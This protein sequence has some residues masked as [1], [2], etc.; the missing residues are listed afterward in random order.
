M[1]YVNALA[2]FSVLSN[3]I[4]RKASQGAFKLVCV[5]ILHSKAPSRSFKVKQ[6]RRSVWGNQHLLKSLQ[7]AQGPFSS[8]F[9]LMLALQLLTAL[10][11]APRPQASD[12]SSFAF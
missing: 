2:P 6:L 9:S 11:L 3:G 12:I 10:S 5:C 4:L 1:P 7:F 8:W